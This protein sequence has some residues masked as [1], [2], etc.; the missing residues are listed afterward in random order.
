MP[1]SFNLGSR[2][3]C[4]AFLQ[5]RRAQFFL[6]LIRLIFPIQELAPLQGHRLIGRDQLVTQGLIDRIQPLPRLR[7]IRP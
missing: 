3:Q 5:E 6:D 1:A 7:A 4:H 2:F